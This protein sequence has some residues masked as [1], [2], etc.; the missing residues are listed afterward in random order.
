[1][2]KLQL[3]LPATSSQ[4]TMND[5]EE[6]LQILFRVVEEEIACLRARIASTRS[7]RRR[8]VNSARL[9]FSRSDLVTMSTCLFSVLE[10]SA[11]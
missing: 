1:M 4:P 11:N 2:T 10:L 6:I 7:L 5:T 9:K 8:R 3:I